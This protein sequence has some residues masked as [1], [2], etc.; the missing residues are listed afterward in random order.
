MIQIRSRWNNKVLYVAES[1]SDVRTALDEAVR[2]GANLADANL[3]DANLADANLAGAYLAGAYLADANLADAKG[4]V[5][6]RCNDLL[7]LLD[8]PGKI[9][10]YKLVNE[11]GEGPQ[12]GGLKYEIGATLEI[13]NADTDSRNRCAGGINVATLPWCLK[14]WRPGYRVLLVEFTKKDIAAIPMGDGK[15]RLFRC[16]VVAEKKIDPV[17]LGLVQVERAAS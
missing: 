15:F 12:Y 5:P 3:A 7:I 4:F 1:A 10:A 13:K 6:E 8:Q 9:R 17:A 14:N 16:K 11:K 2:A